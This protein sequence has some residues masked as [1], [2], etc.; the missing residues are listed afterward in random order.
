MRAS[1]ATELDESLLAPTLEAIK[2]GSPPLAA[3][4]DEW[5]TLVP[6]HAVVDRE[7]ARADG[8]RHG[9][10]LSERR[11][12][13]GEGDP[14]R[15]STGKSMIEG[16]VRRFRRYARTPV[17]IFAYLGMAQ[18]DFERLRG[19]L[20]LRA[21]VPRPGRETPMGIRPVRRQLVRDP[22]AP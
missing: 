9:Q 4:M 20:V 11:G 3:W 14:G 7:A 21:L 15:R 18:M 19:G 13:A 6:A 10:P 2:T 1:R 12:T 17:A 5:L 22:H 8:D 16:L